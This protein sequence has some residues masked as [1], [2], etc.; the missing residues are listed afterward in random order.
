MVAKQEVESGVVRKPQWSEALRKANGDLAAAEKI[1]VCMRVSENLD[2][3]REREAAEDHMRRLRAFNESQAPF[4][5]GKLFL[6]CFVVLA[7]VC[8]VYLLM[9]DK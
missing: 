5:T 1:Y 9:A 2:T 8:V 7:T 3:E 6:M 4:A